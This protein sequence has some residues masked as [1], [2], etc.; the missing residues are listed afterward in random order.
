MYLSITEFCF[1]IGYCVVQRSQQSDQHIAEGKSRRVSTTSL[2]PFKATTKPYVTSQ[3]AIHAGRCRVQRAVHL[4]GRR[5]TIAVLSR[6]MRTSGAVSDIAGI[7]QSRCSSL[8]SLSGALSM[9]LGQVH[10]YATTPW[11]IFA[12]RYARL[13][14]S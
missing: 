14:Q 9:L 1:S 10:L 5:N 6:T 3:T 13:M 2:I 7:L 4:R 12:T 8:S 11:R